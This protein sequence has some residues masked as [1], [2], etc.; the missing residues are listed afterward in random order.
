[1]NSLPILGEE[2]HD[3]GRLEQPFAPNLV[4]VD[5]IMVTGVTMAAI[6][7]ALGPKALRVKV[8]ACLDTKDHQEKLLNYFPNLQTLIP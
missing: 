6:A 3:D 7:K 4:V 8:L 2:H 5:D 1:M